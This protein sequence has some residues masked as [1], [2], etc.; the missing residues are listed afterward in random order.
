LPY[1]EHQSSFDRIRT[2]PS[3]FD[4]S[5][6]EVLVAPLALLSCPS[7]SVEPVLLT[8]IASLFSGPPISGLN[9]ITCDYIGNG[10]YIPDSP[11]DPALTDGPVGLQFADG[12]VPNEQVARILDGLSSTLLF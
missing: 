7:S 8:D 3:T 10:G 9:S 4:L 2:A 5:N 11:L 6:Q 12:V 1:I